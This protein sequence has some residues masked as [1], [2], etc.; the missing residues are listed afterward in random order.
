MILK[1]YD[2]FNWITNDIIILFNIL[3]MLLLSQSQIKDG[4]KISLSFILP[5]IAIVQ[6]SL[7]LV[8]AD[9]F[10][11]NFILILLFVLV[12]IQILLLLIGKTI[13]KYV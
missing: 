3:L 2:S 8:V 12:F 7:G 4:F 13:S 5:I 6:F 9:K 11:D 1:S 10:E